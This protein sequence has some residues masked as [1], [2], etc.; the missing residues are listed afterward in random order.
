MKYS[1]SLP[2]IAESSQTLV[3]RIDDVNCQTHINYSMEIVLVSSGELIMRI[4]EKD[5]VI[6]KDEAIFV[7]PFEKHS[8]YTPHHSSCTVITFS[9]S[10][11]TEVFKF[12]GNN[13]YE[14]RVFRISDELK[15][16]ILAKIKSDSIVLDVLHSKALLIPLAVEI[17]DKCKPGVSK[18]SS[19]D[20]FLR[21]IDLVNE[22]SSKGYTADDYAKAI[23]IHSVTLS[24]IFKSRSGIGFCDFCNSIKIANAVNLLQTTNLNMGEVAF[25]TGFGSIR[26][27]NRQF[28]KQVGISP[29]EFKKTLL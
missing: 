25:K 26:S 20:I 5:H 13:E 7:L 16:F 18:D 3:R 4:S 11:I 19:Q 23:G 29:K 21:L 14:N 15:D 24:R 6:K 22:N 9:A 27:F 10:L 28:Q 1:L 2:S 12:V 17:T 8:F